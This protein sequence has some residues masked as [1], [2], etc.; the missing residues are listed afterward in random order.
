M[1]SIWINLLMSMVMLNVGSALYAQDTDAPTK[2]A[3][4]KKDAPKKEVIKDRAALEAEFE[5]KMSGV[6]LVGRFTIDGQ[7]KAPH[8]ERY[9]IHKV[10]KLKDDL[11]RFQA[12]IQYMKHD[13]T[14]PIDIKVIWSGDTPVITMTDST[15]PL[16]GTFSCRVLIHG[17]RYAGTWQHDK[18][19]G[20]MFGRLERAPKEPA[21]KTDSPKTKSA[22]PESKN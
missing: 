4:S 7:E 11:W 19:G 22:R 8:E 13:V 17:E 15:I 5:K 9:T 10:S 20:L 14:I 2:P 16:M 1:R 18:V 21:A 12:R 3:S 6:V